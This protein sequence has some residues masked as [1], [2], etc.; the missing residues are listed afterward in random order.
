[1][2][3]VNA[4]AGNGAFRT[5]KFQKPERRVSVLSNDKNKTSINQIIVTVS[6]IVI[7]TVIFFYHSI[8]YNNIADE[9]SLALYMLDHGANFYPRVL[10]GEY[11]RL[12]TCMFLHFDATHLFTNMLSLFAIG[13]IIEKAF[14][15][16]K[17]L[18]IFLISGLGAGVVSNLYHMANRVMAVCAGASGAVFGL[19]G[20]LICLA[21]FKQTERYGI[22]SRRVPAAIILSL[23]LSSASRDGLV[24]AAA[25]IG[26]LIIGFVVSFVIIYIEYRKRKAKKR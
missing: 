6:L 2:S 20:A 7:N 5:L 14:G 19:A 18:L 3:V 10:D 15:K 26:G 11:Y 9:A 23:V 4:R 1:V 21:V 17:Y 22:D 24:D 16:F 12:L 25:H 8:R 13:G